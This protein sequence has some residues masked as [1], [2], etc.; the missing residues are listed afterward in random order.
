MH[1]THDT[2]LALG[3]PEQ[4][5]WMN[6]FKSI[7]R[8]QLDYD[9]GLNLCLAITRKLERGYFLGDSGNLAC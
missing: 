8:D 5:D 7:G 6:N 9:I 1:I 2:F 3:F 4:A